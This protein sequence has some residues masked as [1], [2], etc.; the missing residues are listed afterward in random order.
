MEQL[1]VPQHLD[2]IQLL[3]VWVT[4]E[5]VVEDEHR[6][7]FL[8]EP[9]VIVEVT[10]LR[11]QVVEFFVRQ[12]AFLHQAVQQEL[13]V[14]RYRIMDLPVSRDDDLEVIDERCLMG[15]DVELGTQYFLLILGIRQFFHLSETSSLFRRISASARAR[16]GLMI[17]RQSLPRSHRSERPLPSY[18]GTRPP[19]CLPRTQSSTKFGKVN[20]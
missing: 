1:F 18:S 14:T 4:L 6:F 9:A 19:G 13:L 7:V 3:V 20:S 17:L 11:A 8:C 5:P 15:R 2:R 10:L 16:L 12:I